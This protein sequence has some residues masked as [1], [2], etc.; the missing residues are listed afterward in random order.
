MNYAIVFAGGTGVRMNSSV[1]KQFLPIQG[2]PVLVHTLE[3][4]QQSE[5]IDRIIVVC[6]KEYISLVNEFSKQ[7]ELTK[8]SQV[9][10]GGKTAFESQKIGIEA[11]YRETQ[12]DNT[13]IFIHDGVRPLI[14]NEL[15]NRCFE[16]LKKTGSAI[17]VSPA[18]ETIAV[19][20]ENKKIVKTMPRQNCVLARAPQVFYLKDIYEAHQKA[21]KENKEYID[22]ASMF[23]D[24]G[25]TL[26]IVEGPTE[27]IKITTQYDYLVSKLLLCGDKD[28]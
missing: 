7:Y 2:K 28:E 22:S 14:N 20:N 27:N 15:I 13:G 4:F 18:A 3:K 21:A 19:F 24:Q 12:N 9:V 17:T 10:P 11:V 23:L 1:P 5:I 16:E 25:K 6:L 26:G 8:I